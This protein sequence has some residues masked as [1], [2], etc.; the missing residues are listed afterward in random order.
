MATLPQAGGLRQHSF[1]N[2]SRALRF[3]VA[4]WLAKLSRLAD[5]DAEE[6]RIS[7]CW[8]DKAQQHIHSGGFARPVRSQKTKHLSGVDLEVQ[9]VY[10]QFFR[11]T[12]AGGAVFNAQIP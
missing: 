12:S 4:V 3:G 10:S 9:V 8:A 7:G 6:Q 11:L 1:A 5:V 2:S